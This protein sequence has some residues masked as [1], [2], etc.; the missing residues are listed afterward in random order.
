MDLVTI[1]GILYRYK[2]LVIGVTAAVAVGVVLFAWV[3]LLLPPERSALPNRY[4]PEALVLIDAIGPSGGIGAILAQAGLSGL[5]GLPGLALSSSGGYGELAVRLL[6]GNTILDAI[7]HEFDIVGR[8]G[9]T[10][11]VKDNARKA[12]RERCTVQF[13]PTSQTVSIKYQDID[14]HF[15]TD[16]VNRMV[17]LLD[18]RFSTIGGNR[19]TRKRNMLQGKLVEIEEDMVRLEED[20]QGFQRRYGTID[21][22]SSAREHISILAEMRAQLISKEIEAETYAQFARMEDPVAA[23]LKAERDQLQQAITEM[24]RRFFGGSATPLRGSGTAGQA[25][26]PGVDIPELAVEF[27]RL[28]RELRVQSRI[29]E[30]LTQQYEVARL[31]AEGEEIIFQVLEVAE[32]GAFGLGI[33]HHDLDL[34]AAALQA[35]DLGAVKALAHLAGE[36][37]ERESQAACF[38]G[39]I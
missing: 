11:F 5:P 25:L 39:K 23:R 12:V 9:I 15:A 20:I 19:E 29:Y 30:V 35:H 34:I 16:V 32:A 31:S 3:S 2:W 26:G 28:E 1:F 7:V 36:V 13:D 22:Q 37:V 10:R 17:E 18:Q 4:E 6:R 33:A 21:P 14:P 27:G 24:E 38:V 8:H